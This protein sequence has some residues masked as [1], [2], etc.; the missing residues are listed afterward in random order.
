MAGTSRETVSRVFKLLE[1][2]HLVFKQGHTLMIP[3]YSYFKR[4]FG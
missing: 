3:D 2:R 4:V 1:D